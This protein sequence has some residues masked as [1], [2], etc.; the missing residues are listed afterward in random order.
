MTHGTNSEVINVLQLFNEGELQKS[1]VLCRKILENNPD[2]SDVLHILGMINFATGR[3]KESI[4]HISRAIEINPKNSAAHINLGNSY[5]AI[6]QF[7]SALACYK[8]AYEITPDSFGYYLRIAK[9]YWNT[10]Q[11]V[12]ACECFKKVL[13]IDPNH[14]GAIYSLN[15]ILLKIDQP[16]DAI[17]AFGDDIKIKLPDTL[18]QLTPY[19]IREQHQWFEKD[20]VF[21]G[22]YIQP[23]M[24]AIDIGSNFG[25]YALTM[26]KAMQGKGRIWA[27]EPTDKTAQYLTSSL[28]ENNFTTVAV[29]QCAMSDETGKAFL[30]V[31]ENSEANAL[32]EN[33]ESDYED[34]TLRTLDDCM[35]E[36]CWENIDFLK[37]DAEG[38]EE[39]IINGG[40]RFFQ[41]MS[42]LVMFEAIDKTLISW[43][44]IDAFSKIGYQ[45]FSYLASLG[46]LVPFNADDSEQLPGLNLFCG[47]ENTVRS[48]EDKNLLIS[49]KTMQNYE[50]EPTSLS[51]WP[52][53]IQNLPCYKILF[54]AA[55]FNEF[56][57]PDSDSSSYFE[58]LKLIVLSETETLEPAMRYKSLVE[59]FSVLC[60]ITSGENV[61]VSRL[62]TLSRVC[63]NLESRQ[64]LKQ[65]LDRLLAIYEDKGYFEI[66]EPFLPVYKDFD[67]GEPQS[68]ENISTWVLAQVLE[69]QEIKLHYSSFLTSFSS[70]RNINKIAET[71]F[72]REGMQRRLSLIKERYDLN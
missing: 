58:A 55:N 32:C 38:H 3:K 8:K 44:V 31:G 6:E 22:N 47:N 60:A 51:D 42:P 49:H 35:D 4:D 16:D 12:E 13:E 14:E 28:K 29:I 9:V 48:L 41:K 67:G 54:G 11:L 61:P 64:M 20:I 53:K 71:G 5:V 46:I 2:Q 34:V 59:S 37:I 43:N 40:A 56:E 63:S 24:Q 57:R 27:F 50:L 72:L 62:I 70:L 18:Q 7:E 69:L 45:H 17:L 66:D 33:P 65:T 26:A 36:F 68:R 25:V 39:K 10:G 19:V 15:L 21:V 30:S 1:E 52:C 23:G